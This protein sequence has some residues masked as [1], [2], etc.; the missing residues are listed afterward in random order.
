MK[1]QKIFTFRIEF[2]KLELTDVNLTRSAL[3]EKLQPAIKMFSLLR[4]TIVDSYIDY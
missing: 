4:G 2:F 1:K 3:C